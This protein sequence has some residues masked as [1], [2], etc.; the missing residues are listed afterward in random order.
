MMEVTETYLKRTATEAAI[1]PVCHNQIYASA[2]CRLKGSWG[3]D[4]VNQPIVLHDRAYSSL[5]YIHI[6]ITKSYYVVVGH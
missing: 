3:I 1:L 4:K 2:I 6:K 5:V